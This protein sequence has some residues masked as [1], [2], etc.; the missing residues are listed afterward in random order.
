VGKVVAPLFLR[1]VKSA[2][3]RSLATIGI[4]IAR[5]AD[6]DWS[7]TAKLYPVSADHGA[8]RV[9]QRCRSAITSMNGVPG[10]SKSTIDKMVLSG[11]QTVVERGPG[12]GRYLEKTMKA[13][14]PR[15]AISLKR[16]SHARAGSLL[17]PLF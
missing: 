7:D 3:N 9:L 8:G 15:R 14:H 13:G 17:L 1:A 11:L 16:I 6:H 10:S 12:T 5:V 4:R 2:A